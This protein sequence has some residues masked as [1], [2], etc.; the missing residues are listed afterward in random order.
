MNGS[1][2]SV[3]LRRLVVRTRIAV[4]LVLCCGA[5]FTA[6]VVRQQDRSM[7]ENHISRVQL[8]ARAVNIELIRDLTGT[9]ADLEKPSYLRLKAELDD[10]KHAENRCRFIYLLDLK[11]VPA[12]E[13]PDGR[14]GHNHLVFLVDNEPADSEDCSPAGQVYDEAPASFRNVFN[15]RQPFVEGPYE[16]RWGVWVTALTPLFDTCGREVVAVLA[17]DIAADDWTRS[18]VWAAARPVFLTALMVAIVLVGS[19]LLAHRRYGAALPAGRERLLEP[20]LVAG[21]GVVI[22]LCVSYQLHQQADKNR[23]DV[24]W[25]L[26]AGKARVIA[27]QLRHLRDKELEGLARFCESSE[28]INLTEFQSYTDHLTRDPT[29]EL[30]GWVEAVPAVEKEAF[31]RKTRADG[32]AGFDLW[33][34]DADDRRRPAGPRDVYYPLVYAVPINNHTNSSGYDFGSDEPCRTMLEEA[35]RTGLP[36]AAPSWALSPAGNH[37]RA[38]LCCRPVFDPDR[39]RIRGF[40]VA[41]ILMEPL[42][43]KGMPDDLAHL[44]IMMLNGPRAADMLVTSHHGISLIEGRL[45]VMQP[46]MAFG[47][48]FAVTVHAGPAFLRLYPVRAG[49]TALATGLVITAAVSIVIGVILRRRDAL[50]CLVAERTAALSA[51]ERRQ[52]ATLYCIGDG[53]ISTDA[54]RRIVSI[55]AA[56]ERLLGCRADDVCGRPVNEV[57]RVSDARTGQPIPD[58]VETALRRG[59]PVEPTDHTVLTAQGGATY[60][61]SHSCAPI[62]DADG[63]VLGAV[64][65]FRDVTRDYQYREQLRESQER[66]DQLA[67]QSRT[68]AWEVDAQ[69]RYTY[70]SRSVA[71]VI[72]YRPD[73]VVGRMHFYDLHPAQDREAFKAS[74]FDAFSRKQCFV[75]FVNSVES[76]DGRTLWV[77]TSGMPMLDEAGALCGYRGLDTD[78]TERRRSE[79]AAKRQTAKLAA[80]VSTM[81]EGVIFADADNVIIEV[82]DYFCRFV[83]KGRD[84]ILGRSIED[85]HSGA[86]LAGILKRI[87]E[88]RRVPG[89][90]PHIIQRSLGPAEVILRMQPIYRDGRYDGVLLNVI[91]VTELVRARAA[92]ESANAAK[93]LFLANMSHEIRTPMNGIIGMTDLALDTELTDE[94]REYLTTVKASAD[95]LLDLINDILD[96]SKIEAGQL[97]LCEAG[98][99]LRSTVETALRTLSLKAHQKHLELIC[100]IG[101]DIPDGLVGDAPRL[102]QVLLNL[103]GNAVKFTE[104]GEVEVAVRQV[105]RHAANDDKRLWLEFSVRDTGI[106]IPADRL[107]AV[108]EPFTQADNSI[109][110]RYGGTGLGLSICRRLVG[111]LGGKLTV[112]SEEGKGSTFTFTVPFGLDPSAAEMPVVTSGEFHG[113]AALVVDDNQTNR[114]LLTT[115]LTNW[116]LR[117][118]EATCGRDAVAELLRAH[119]AGSPYR[120][121]LIDVCMP[122][123][124][125]FETARRIREH[126]QLNDLVIMM[127]TSADRHDDIARCRRMGLAGYV[128]KPVGQSDL[129]D[130]IVTALGRRPQP[131][132]RQRQREAPPQTRAATALHVLL[133]E[134]NAANQH[135]ARRLLEK[136]GHIV[137]V[138]ANGREA[139]DAVRRERFDVVLMDVQMPEMDGYEATAAIRAGETPG[140]RRLPII[141]LTAHAISG[142]RQRCLEA[143]MDDYLSKPI[144]KEDLY[145]KVERWGAV[146]TSTPAENAIEPQSHA[147]DPGN[148]LQLTVVDMARLKNLTGDDPALISEVAEIFLTESEDLMQTIRDSLAERDAETLSKAAHSLKGSVA[149]FGADRAFEA[150]RSVEMA[151]R[152]NEL[153]GL[154]AAVQALAEQVDAVRNDLERLLMAKEF[155]A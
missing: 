50:E 18:L 110:R 41:A 17:M 108:F 30:W 127:L 79:E 33:E 53:V 147:M 102:R 81:E 97:S 107:Q 69:G 47:R 84:Q 133:A 91:D 46:V 42:M 28:N 44:D 125:G 60:Q 1:Q 56:A 124:D 116:G 152:N 24:F 98:F 51:S 23:N 137:T 39:D 123:V 20:I 67:E 136:R 93:S 57:F 106:G 71:A 114:R 9:S 109:T 113:I 21:I 80:M 155:S 132:G 115:L 117:P 49:W 25:H 153:D 120:L 45:S 112:V 104:Q 61:I 118:N 26:A 101:P 87:A 134:D 148:A 142:D 66:F 16:D 2:M 88:F 13:A 150:A 38:I 7:R 29:V 14:E 100:H 11:P 141:A 119:Q 126:P 154:D 131:S 52:A 145:E 58:P 92:A 40:A 77:S 144:R 37:R 103:V 74:V 43:A 105:E 138:V 63:T 76:K 128:V 48:T 12:S 65:V 19:R 8:L 96:F 130:A 83:G 55:N 146:Q 143:G 151:S 73:E 4:I 3:S 59:A 35:A 6:S 90:K 89:A 122:E 85:F 70:V 27:D 22:T 62:H 72:G 135:L 94:Q 75:D 121:A 95:A 31:V 68:F 15:T 140:G 36:A 139:I 99:A 64:L 82:N 129:W 111:L 34:N 10:V 78:I 32:V 54:A 86:A 5:L 149:N